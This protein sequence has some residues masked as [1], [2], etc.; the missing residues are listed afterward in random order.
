M[1]LILASLFA[2]PL[3]AGVAGFGFAVGLLLALVV[4]STYAGMF[5]SVPRMLLKWW[6]QRALRAL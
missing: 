5:Y 2:S 6:S 3:L 1:D 4:V